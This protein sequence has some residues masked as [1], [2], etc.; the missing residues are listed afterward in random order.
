MNEQNWLREVLDDAVKA[1]KQWPDWALEGRMV[2]VPPASM[3][4]RGALGV[5]PDW[6]ECREW[7]I[8][9][10]VGSPASEFKSL[11]EGH[12][13]VIQ[14]QEWLKKSLSQYLAGIQNIAFEFNYSNE[15]KFTN[16]LTNCKGKFSQWT[17]TTDKWWVVNAKIELPRDNFP[18]EQS[19]LQAFQ[20]RGNIFYL[21]GNLEFSQREEWIGGL[22]INEMTFNGLYF[23]DKQGKST[24]LL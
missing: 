12:Q 3:Q 4:R 23:I 13:E 24:K 10:Y 1:K 22:D 15:N 20:G 2:P 16:R 21:S 19:Y 7:P 14:A 8:P 6:I 18:D 9:V 11:I 5:T 17:L